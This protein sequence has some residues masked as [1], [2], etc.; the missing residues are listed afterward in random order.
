VTG[1]NGQPQRRHRRLVEFLSSNLIDHSSSGTS[2]DLLEDA[3]KQLFKYGNKTKIGFAGNTAITVLNRVVRNNTSSFFDMSAPLNKLE[4]YK[5]N[6]REF[7]HPYGTLQLI[8]HPLLSE[9]STWA[10]QIW[11][12]DLAYLAWVKMKTIGATNFKDDIKKEDGYTGRKGRFRTVAGC[13][14]RSRKSTGASRSAPTCRNSQPN[15]ARGA[16]NRPP[17]G[18]LVMWRMKCH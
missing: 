15:E 12:V 11:V 7:Y 16:G 17:P 2:I 18:G 10:S 1:A 6:V 3:F 8:N 13:G 9:D 4:T 5:L 14:W